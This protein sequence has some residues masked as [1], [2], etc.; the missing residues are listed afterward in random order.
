MAQ[1]AELTK[2]QM[3]QE[4]ELNL[5]ITE[6]ERRKH[7]TKMH[8]CKIE[9]EALDPSKKESALSRPEDSKLLNENVAK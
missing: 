7:E 6:M 4:R 1:A 9:A 3:E 8:D 5:I 2:M